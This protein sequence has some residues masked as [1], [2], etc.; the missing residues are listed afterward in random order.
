MRAIRFSYVAALCLVVSAC[1]DNASLP[2]V[3]AQAIDAVVGPKC[4]DGIDNDGDGKSD[5][6]NDPGC[7]VPN[8]DDETDD[9][10]SGP[11]CPQCANGVDDDGNGSTDFPNDPG[12]TSAGDPFEFVMNPQACGAGLVIKQVPSNGIDT[13]M[14]DTT[15]SMSGIGSTCGGGGNAAGYAYQISLTAP[16][17]LVATTEGSTLGSGAAMDTVLDLRGSNCTTS[18]IECNDNDGALKTSKLTRS[19]PAGN[20]YLIVEGKD[21]TI[22]GTYKIEINLYTGEGESCTSTPQCGPGLV[23]RTPLMGTMGM[24]CTKPQCNDGV[25]DDMDGKNDYPTDPGCDSTSDND[26]TDTCPNGATCPACSNGVDDDSDGQTDYPMDTSCSAAAGNSEACTGERDPITAIVG[27]TTSGTLVGAR[28]DHNPSCGSDGGGDILYTLQL[29]AMRSIVLDTEGTTGDTVLS[30]LASTCTEPSLACDDD[31]GTSGSSSRITRSNM[32]AGVYIVAVDNYNGTKPPAPYDLHLS[33]VIAPG[34]ACNPADTLGGALMCPLTNPCGGATGAMICQPSACGDGMD[35]DTDGKTDYPMDPGCTAIDDTDEADGC[36]SGPGPTCPECADGIDNDGDGQTDS[37]DTN[38]TSPSVPSEGCVSTEPV[39]TL[40][41]PVTPGTTVGATNDVPVGCGT[42]SNTAGDRTYGLTVPAMRSLRID[43]DSTITFDGIV[44]LLG[45]TCAGAP[46]QCSDTPE[47]IEVTNVPA[48]QYFYVVD[49]YS[50]GTGTYAIA[51]SGIIQNGASCESPL[52]VNGAITCGPGFSCRGTAGSRT[53]QSA[54]CSDGLDNDS[55]GIADFPNDPGCT[56]ISDNDESDN[57][58]SGPG[59]PQCSDALDNDGDGQFDYPNDS[60]CNAA[61]GV[62]ESCVTT[63]GVSALVLPLTSDSTAAAS[64]DTQP[65]A[66]CSSATNTAPDKTYQLTVPNL[67]SLSITNTNSFDAVV[68]LLGASCGGAPVVCSDTP[69]DLNLTNVAAGT[70]YY[71]VDGYGST[72]GGTYTIGVSGKIAPGQSCESPLAVSGALTCSDGYACKGT[73]GAR[74]CQVTQC[75]DGV[76]NDTDTYTDYPLDPG[77][78]SKSDDDETDTCPG[79]GCPVCFNGMDDDNDTKTDFPADP[80]CIAA[81]GTS[82]QPCTATEAVTELVNPMLMDTTVGA[83][84]DQHPTCG[85]SSNTAGDKLY[86]IS[87]PAV[88]NFNILNSNGFDA[89]VALYNSTCGGTAVVC[90]DSPEDL[91]F[92]SLP[93]GRYYYLVDGWSTATGAYTI[94]VN[95]KIVN[96]ESCES[97]L[98]QSGALTCNAGYACH[99]T[100]G[101]RTC[102][103]AACGDGMDNDS[104]GVTDADD[105]GCSSTSD[106]DETNPATAAACSNGM[107]DDTDTLV[108]YPADYGCATAGGASEVF[109][110]PEVDATSLIT[111]TPVTGTTTGKANNFASTTCVSSSGEDVALALRLP[112][113][114]TSLDLDLSG[115]TFDTVMTIRDVTCATELACD[116]ESGAGSSS[117]ITTG[118]LSPG[119]YSVIVDGWSGADGAFTLAVKGTVASGTS[120]VSP[121]FASG[122]LACATGTT[123]TGTPAKCQ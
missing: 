119:V 32:N 73:A 81:S 78:A 116:D 47:T 40:V 115:T 26:E 117:K 104:D 44:K 94:T 68:E 122:V 45:S 97:P 13:G 106:D 4:S 34:G 43:V 20:Y 49:G 67:T 101:S 54:A 35:N 5:Y 38:C 33:G 66:A 12:C 50:T 71:I 61:S 51:V 95:G 62:T 55:D 27:P 92:D 56:S 14:L 105:P 100:V 18:E 3:D 83:T 84:D 120:C 76:N 46:L 70:Y 22:A 60:S 86:G 1:G 9:C 118:P 58:P 48:G 57:C 39:D 113:P 2:P 108:D 17:V 52:A 63:E 64:N 121:L 112:V 30:L 41:M 91:H 85:S 7:L 88:T 24:V 37:A 69:E 77:C 6:P 87:L 114:V 111:T 123:C 103:L 96:G 31:G 82:E 79:A 19:L 16:K 8:Q 21:T 72:A 93:A 98:A 102:Q 99:G 29:P 65:P 75:N 80:D 10:P 109:C 28:D 110:M 23:C 42:T 107:D 59:C 15:M 25:D 74:T 89:A 36:A 90:N 11:N 53:C